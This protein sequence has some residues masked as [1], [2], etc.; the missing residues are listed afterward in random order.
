MC[1]APPV[2]SGRRS[3]VAGS[4]VWV[5]RVSRGLAI[6]PGPS[7]VR[8][9]QGVKWPCALPLRFGP[10]CLG[11]RWGGF[12]CNRILYALSPTPHDSPRNRD[13]DF[14][15]ARFGLHVW[16]G[17]PGF[18]PL[19]VSSPPPGFMG[20]AA[21][22]CRPESP[23]GGGWLQLVPA[24]FKRCVCARF[25]PESS[26]RVP[27]LRS[28]LSSQGDPLGTSSALCSTRCPVHR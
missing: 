26:E 4:C 24:Y 18:A 1:S 11:G 15:S 28:S 23:K 9:D 27:P 5:G 20:R 10:G 25:D 6:G 2:C 16:L 8:S 13:S 7:R 19:V 22:P 12:C 3:P 14:V 17:P 21:G